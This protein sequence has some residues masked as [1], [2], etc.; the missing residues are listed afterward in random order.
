MPVTLLLRELDHT[1]TPI[2]V[3]KYTCVSLPCSGRYPFGPYDSET[4]A[5]IASKARR[6]STP[7]DT[8]AQTCYCVVPG[9]FNSF[10]G[11]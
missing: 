4:A 7:L 6:C 5:D 11:W 9:Y 8:P 10:L 3:S 1:V 2:A